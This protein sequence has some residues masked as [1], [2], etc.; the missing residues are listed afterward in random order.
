MIHFCS[1]SLKDFKY[2]T[3]FFCIGLFPLS[4]GLSIPNYIPIFLILLLIQFINITINNFK[5]GLI[6]FYFLYFLLPPAWSLSLGSIMP[7]L[8]IRRILIIILYLVSFRDNYFINTRNNSKFL[9]ISLLLLFL[10]Y[11]A[12]SFTSISINSTFI[13]LFSFVL[14]N[15]LLFI[16]ISNINFNVYEINTIILGLLL[17]VF[18]LHFFG[19]IESLIGFNNFENLKINHS[20]QEMWTSYSEGFRLGVF[21]RIHSLTNHPFTYG[22]FIAF[23]FPFMIYFL[24]CIEKRYRIYVYILITLSF[25]CLFKI[26]TRSVILALIVGLTTQVSFFMISVKYYKRTIKYLIVI[27]LLCIPLL[28]SENNLILLTDSIFFWKS[29]KY[30]EGSTLEGRID[31]IT[32]AINIQRSDVLTGKGAGTTALFEDKMV[33]TYNDIGR[34]ENFWVQKFLE[35]GLFGIIAYSTFFLTLIFKL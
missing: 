35:L 17:S 10:S 3:L 5:R 26:L 13:A 25:Y 20:K 33:A 12:S 2:F 29:S 1:A 9:S 16:L 34:F 32:A 14:E 11:F 6:I 28:F 7:L 23:M 27:I 19:L 4:L 31:M 21:G 18:V 24:T 15:L 8:T 30:V 22:A